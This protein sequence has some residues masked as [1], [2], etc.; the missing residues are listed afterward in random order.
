MGKFSA[1]TEKFPR[2]V[3]VVDDEPLIRWSVA[4]SFS[5]LGFDVEEA[6]DAASALRA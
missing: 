1:A 4:E 3:L 2:H 6:A 5:D